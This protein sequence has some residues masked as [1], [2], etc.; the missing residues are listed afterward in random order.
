MIEWFKS[1]YEENVRVSRGT[2]HNYLGMMLSYSNNQVRILMADYVKN[3]IDG[4]IGDTHRSASTPAGENLFQVQDEDGQVKLD[5]KRTRC[6]HSTVVQLLSVTMRCR[7]DIQTAV[8]FL[9]TQVKG[10]DEDDWA[11]LRQVLKY[12]C[13]IV[14]LSLTLD[15]S[16]L[17]LAHWWVNVSF[18]VHLDYRSHTGAVLSVGKGGLTSISKKQKLNTKSSTEAEVVG[19]DDA[20][21]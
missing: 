8:A 7:R 4:I 10:L 6:F 19:V 9:T 12:L 11:K 1:I 20:S 13:G 5:E 3:V 2:T 18:A 21:S 14:Y 15:A 17:S 16:Q